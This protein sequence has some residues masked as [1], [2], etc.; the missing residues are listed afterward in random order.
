MQL[1]PLALPAWAKSTNPIVRRHLGL[2]WRTLPPEV[3]PLLSWNIVWGVAFLL[4]GLWPALQDTL[5]IL[6]ILS[7]IAL[8]LTLLGYGHIL[9]TIARDSAQ[10]MHGEIRNK[11]LPLLVVSPISSHHILLGKVAA[12]CWRRMD[13]WLIVSY[14]VVITSPPALFAMYNA[15]W[16]AQ[17]QLW[18]LIAATI[19]GSLLVTLR[20]LIEPLMVGALGVLLGTLLPYRA[21]A[22]SLAAASSAAIFA[23]LWWLRQWPAVRGVVQRGQ[24]IVPPDVGLAALAEFALPVLV[25]LLVA[26]LALTLAERQMR[27]C[28]AT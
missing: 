2:Y 15:V 3:G 27:R 1:P 16:P 28:A 26:L 21:T 9:L 18:A 8:P 7:F 25:P 4:V 12:A 22:V 14:A 17:S 6:L 13:D 19:L 23:L 5:L 11:T 24:V 20:L 10:A